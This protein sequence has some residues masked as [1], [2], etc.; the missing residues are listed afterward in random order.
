VR[1][2]DLSRHDRVVVRDVGLGIVRSMLE[3]DVHPPSE[4]L[5]VEAA[6]VDADLVADTPGFLARRSSG[7]GHPSTSFKELLRR[8]LVTRPSLTALSSRGRNVRRDVA[9]GR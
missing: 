4:L 2:R 6:P 5:E 3:L 9:A 1:E 7:L 8:N